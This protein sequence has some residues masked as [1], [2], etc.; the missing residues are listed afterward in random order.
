[1]K[2]EEKIMVTV[3]CITYNQEKY[4][5]KALESF[6]EQKTK[7][8][9]KVFV[10]DDCSKDN[11]PNII[12]EFAN[13]YP[14]IIIPFIRKNNMGAQR[15]LI[16]MCNRAESPY[17]AFCEGDDYWID[18]Y[19]L[20]KQVDFM[21]ENKNC[22]VCFHNAR[23][24]IETDDNT[25][26]QSNSFKDAET[27]LFIYPKGLKNFK[28]NKKFFKIT[29]FIDL[30]FIQTSSIFYRW[31]YE[32]E[33]PEWYYN[34]ILGDYTLTAIQVGTGEIG[35]LEDV[36][37]VYRKHQEGVYFFKNHD[38]YMLKTRKDWVDLLLDLKEYF[39]KYYDGY[40]VNTIQERINR[41]AFNYIKILFKH[42][43]NDE[44]LEFINKNPKIATDVLKWTINEQQKFSLINKRISSKVTNKILQSA[45]FGK[46]IKQEMGDYIKKGN[47]IKKRKIF[48]RY[49][50]YALIPKK[51]N[52]WVFTSFKKKG[53][54]DNT[55]Y[56]YEYINA[57]NPEIQAVW[58]TQDQEVINYLKEKE[59]PVCK[60]H[61]KEGR[62][63][64]SRAKLAFTDRYIMSDYRSSAINARTKTV[65]LWHGVG[66]K[67]L[68]NFKQTDIKGVRLS[69]DIIPNKQDSIITRI[70][71]R[72]LYIK[73][74][75]YRELCEKYFLLLG[76]GKEPI[77]ALA[78]TNNVPEKNCFVCGY[79][80]SEKLYL[81][82]DLKIDTYK[83]LYAPTFRWNS[84]KERELVESFIEFAPELSKFLE[85]NNAEFIIR[86]HPH[87]WRNYRNRI[88]AA[89]NE[90]PRISMDDKKDV[91]EE[92]NTYSLIISDY[93]SIV[94]DFLLL[95]RPIVFYCPDYNHYVT[96]EGDFK[97]PF[98][99]YTPGPKT[100][101][102]SDTI[103]EVKTYMDN[104]RRDADFRKEIYDF[105]YDK[106]V[107]DKNNS[108]RIIEELKRRLKIK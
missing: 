105:F 28:K 14:D 104:P 4:I 76:P 41:E 79:P 73:R 95:D 75:P 22:N 27:D 46:K 48:L 71:K 87:T 84:A 38:E 68:D 65:Q 21:E 17:I 83:I 10:G 90:F 35:Y 12:R 25:W 13:K 92:L 26:F 72:I 62:K 89:I 5:R 81:G 7:F 49:W 108:K 39:I 18:E 52:L 67:D 20:Q 60:M 54:L 23:I 37:S 86:L 6:V 43:K 102:W 103:E 31:N 99:D 69:D 96:E 77:T 85:D 64:L 32:A 82:K 45:K 61:S 74:A 106:R 66:L 88:E 40:A 29:E 8:A 19:K 91:N 30:G 70:K 80:R 57:N 42:G 36:M 100:S 24:D 56:L 93:S 33:I 78:K 51:K 16:D 47:K 59:L 15:N 63:I 9:F 107:N 2:K 97:Y 1:M 44:F 50:V 53:Y 94:Y 34:H 11:T 98:N 55:K 101:N 58:L 3:V